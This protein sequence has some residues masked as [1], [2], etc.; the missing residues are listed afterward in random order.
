[1]DSSLLDRD[2]VKTTCELCDMGCGMI[3]YVKEGKLLEVE[4]MPEHPVNQG[5]LCPKGEAAIELVY[6]PDRLKYPMKREGNEWIR[7]SW[8]EAFDLVARNLEEVKEKYGKR[9]IAVYSGIGIGHFESKA[10]IKRFCDVYG[11]ANFFSV[12]SFCFHARAIGYILTCGFLPAADYKNSQ[13]IVVWGK[14]PDYSAPP[15]AASL[16]E[17]RGKGT[18]LIVIDPITIPLAKEADFYL[19]IRPGTDCALASGMLNVIISEGLYDREFVEKWT[20]GF[21][22]LAQ[23]VRDYSPERVEKITWVPAE[24]IR[25][26]ARVYATTKPACIYQGN[27][28]DQNIIGV[29]SARAISILQAVTG[30]I[31]AP[32]GNIS[33]PRFPI[34]YIKLPELVKEKPVGA[35]R[36]PQFF[37]AYREGQ[38]VVLPEAIL[39]ESPYPLKAMI[40]SGAN[41][42]LTSSGSEK[43]RQALKKLDFLVVMDLFMTE[44]AQF[45]DL[46]LPAASYL[47][48]TELRDYELLGIPYVILRKQAIK[49]EEC[50]PD[51]KFWFEL[52]R[53]LGCEKHFPWETKEE[54]IRHLL[55]PTG[56]SL[57]QLQEKP[58]GM[59]YSPV[60]YKGYE[61]TGF[62][63][64]SKKA[65]LYCER[66]EK[67]EQDPL[68]TYRE[69]AESAVN[70]PDIAKEY[71]L[72]LTT[73]TRMVEYYHSQLRNIP[74]LREKA[75]EP[76]AQIHPDTAKDYAIADGQ[77]VLVE[78]RRGSIKI[79]ARITEDIAP[80]VVS[81]PHG[82]SEAN[83]NLLTDIGEE[84]C[85][86]ISGFP[87]LKSLLCRVS[88]A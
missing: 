56:I 28:L 46:V 43:V 62:R 67:R 39:T 7:I 42:V 20:V 85:D 88:K 83:A 4:G 66:L 51:W 2:V 5:E 6:S 9:A 77:T 45:A 31:E 82:W 65:E 74:S 3:A 36:Y 55:K 71:P 12:G 50:L 53:R 60:K 34:T 76:L 61:K 54:V 58:E 57:E 44:T 22:E 72:I 37:Q 16:R 11:V 1:M 70:T 40:I 30:N 29:Q 78:T 21:E 8:D 26:V 24:S 23:H 47:E 59:F 52:A 27:A 73:G 33:P 41:P 81:I 17:A 48:R 84:S 64:P 38:V 32:G 25:E 63:T 19:Q 68:P 15:I 49:V 87:S 86:P 10:Y 13:C 35:D 14:N 18:R 75:P 79:K 69:P 80:S